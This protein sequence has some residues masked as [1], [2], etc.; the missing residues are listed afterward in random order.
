MSEAEQTSHKE[1]M[2]AF[3]HSAHDEGWRPVGD[4]I[5]IHTN[6]FSEQREQRGIISPID[7]ISEISLIQREEAV[8]LI[9]GIRNEGHEIEIK[10]TTP[11]VNDLEI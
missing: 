5:A 4:T 2:F 9:R 3:M 7:N 8:D 10:N 11:L 1:R 6:P